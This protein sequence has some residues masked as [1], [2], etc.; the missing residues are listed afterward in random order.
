[1]L[2]SEMDILLD[3]SELIQKDLHATIDK[4]RKT[5]RGK[6]IPYEDLVTVFF[7]MKIAELENKFENQSLIK[8]N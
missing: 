5:K 2:K 4:I 8:K 7:C 1:M 6:N 3:R